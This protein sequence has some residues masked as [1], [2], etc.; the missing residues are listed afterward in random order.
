M[1]LCNFFIF[2][3]VTVSVMILI[4]HPILYPLVEVCIRNLQNA[5]NESFFCITFRYGEVIR[6]FVGSCSA[7][8]RIVFVRLAIIVII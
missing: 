7:C 4:I 6:S 3:L 5:V 2:I 8:I 1:I